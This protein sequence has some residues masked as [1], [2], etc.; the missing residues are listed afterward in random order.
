M[1]ACR[2]DDLGK[3]WG[4]PVAIH[5]GGINCPRVQLLGDGSLLALGDLH[6]PGYPVVFYGSADGGRTW[7][8]LGTL[9]P[10]KS[11]GRGSCVP[12]RVTELPD[13]SWLV[14]G[15]Y[16]PGEAWKVTDGETLEFFR[17]ADRGKSWS[18]Y[19]ALKPP[20]PISIC[21][22]SIVPLPGGRWLLFARESGGFIPGVRS[23]SNDQGKTWSPLEEL[24]F[25]IQGRT[26]AALLRDGRV[27]LTFRA[28][29][30]PAALWAW[31][32]GPDE[33]MRPFV[34]GIHFNDRASVGLRDGELHIESDG[35][36]GQFTKYIFR[37]P[38]GPEGRIEVTAVAKVVA[39]QGRAATLS[40][41]F[42]GKFRLF[43]D[44]VEMA[45][46][47][48]IRAATTPGMFHT[49]RI[50]REG[51]SM[52]LSI[53]GKESLATDTIESQVCALPWTALKMS[54]YLPSFGNEDGD[55][56]AAGSSDRL[57]EAPQVVLPKDIAPAVTGYS[58]WRSIEIRYDHPRT[59]RRGISWRAD[60][61][62][63][64]D[65]YQLDRLLE[66]EATVSGCD[67]GYS[68]FA[69]LDDGRVFVVNYTDDAAR[70][71]CDASFPPLGV[72][73]IRGTMIQPEDWPPRQRP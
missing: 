45:H 13:G 16:T 59:G 14:H 11:G 38:D 15:A 41:P 61:D 54:P 64:P 19:S 6:G 51:S 57:T 36:C 60:R 58:V 49:Y 20:W 35:A 12:S 56:P 18:F 5:P 44:R 71:N 63:F 69:E 22:A 25:L 8:H 9:D 2:S 43:P 52:A 23:F 55:S 65:Q 4:D 62:G 46:D 39:N 70:W 17:S 73:W 66:V 50:V 37:P 68:G 72:S 47:P 24:P 10:A 27:M 30:G 1:W 26:C 53:D 29:S 34:R 67:Q 7:T 3:T 28:Q 21:E 48:S 32:G 42:I 40:I 33:A 31:V